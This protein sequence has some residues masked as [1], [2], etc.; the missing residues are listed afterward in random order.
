M[1]LHIQNRMTAV[2]LFAGGLSIGLCAASWGWEARPARAP[3]VAGKELVH[4]QRYRL[5]PV[6]S[7]KRSVKGIGFSHRL[8]RPGLLNG[9]GVQASSSNGCGV[10]T[11]DAAGNAYWGNKGTWP[12]VRRWDVETGMV[13][14]VAGSARG[15]LDGS[16]TRARFGGWGY[17]A[18]ANIC[19]SAD[20]KHV[21]L[22]DPAQGGVWRHIDVEAGVVRTWGPWI[23]RVSRGS[24][25][26]VIVKDK[27]GDVY[28][29]R[30]D[31][32][33]MPECKGYKKLKITS[34]KHTSKGTETYWIGGFISG[35][36]L[37]AER[38]KFYWHARNAP[39]VCDL[40]TGET[41]CLTQPGKNPRHADTTGPFEGM[42]WHCPT[43]MSISPG[44]RY[45]FMGGGDSG[46][47]Y[48]LDLER[49]FIDRFARLADGTYG[50]S[51]GH[52][53]DEGHWIT[54]W[55]G[56]AHFVADG[57][58]TWGGSFGIMRIIPVEK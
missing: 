13:T 18:G 25:N 4:D 46:S 56:A 5:E 50:W 9:P 40:E 52:E 54:N 29:F 36:A 35:W 3:Y 1:S 49:K 2:I 15:Y 55:P 39:F 31:G 41:G 24:A 16:V 19:A 26:A 58:A 34:F 48:R 47:F 44:G 43:G 28:A 14:T 38:K 10:L 42:S 17:N 57:S 23:C 33:N 22:R 12:E 7:T 37:D 8:D 30:T 11:V 6:Y 53:K 32:L 27:S 20:G 21:F 45:L 51:E